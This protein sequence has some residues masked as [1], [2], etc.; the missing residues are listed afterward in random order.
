MDAP[1]R[2]L[3]FDSDFDSYRGVIA[4]VRIMEGSFA[5]DDLIAAMQRDAA[6]HRRHWFLYSR[7]APCPR[8]VRR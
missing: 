1:L 7:D 6:R 5:K 4:Y 3:I 8:D 2:A